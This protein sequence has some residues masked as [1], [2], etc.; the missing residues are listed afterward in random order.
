[1]PMSMLAALTG[2]YGKPPVGSPLRKQP[3][4]PA[5]LAGACQVLFSAI[6]IP[7]ARERPKKKT[8]RRLLCP[9]CEGLRSKAL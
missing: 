4:M 8:A 6:A 1:M 9:E 3:L 7:D 5:T 2:L